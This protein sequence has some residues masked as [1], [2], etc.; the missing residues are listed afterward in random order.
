MP[1][2]ISH[3]A[4]GYLFFPSFNHRA[5]FG[6]FVI[7]V[8]LPDLATRPFYIL[9][10][11]LFWYVMPMHTPVG[12]VLLALGLSGLFVAGQRNQVFMLLMAGSALH[13]F[14]DLW[15]KHVHGGYTIF[16]PF[17]WDIYEFG[18]IWPH[19]TL[20][21]LPLWLSIAVLIILWQKRKNKI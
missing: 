7:G 21:F 2:L 8:C 3:I 16:F 20:Y 17:S 13:L 10:P 12:I 4:T 5:W 14:I 15:Q 9:F 19:E 6:L 1:D 11:D 18:Y